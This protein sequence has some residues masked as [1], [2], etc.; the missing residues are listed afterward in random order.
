MA[1]FVLI[2]EIDRS[3]LWDFRAVDRFQRSIDDQMR[4]RRMASE[5]DYHFFLQEEGWFYAAKNPYGSRLFDTPIHD[6]LKRHFPSIE[7]MPLGFRFND[8]DIV[9]LRM[10][11]S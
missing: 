8:T 7:F 9:M 6:Y 11:F 3:V 10:R 4:Y 1:S 5:A 2:E